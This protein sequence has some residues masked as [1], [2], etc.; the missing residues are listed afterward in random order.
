MTSFAQAP[1]ALPHSTF[2]GRYAGH[3]YV[4]SKSTFARGRAIKLVGEELGGAD[5]ISL[6]WYDL[7]SGAVLKPCEMPEAKV[8]AFVSGWR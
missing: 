2:T 1:A 7:A 4:A 6:N 3:R 8:V 5:G